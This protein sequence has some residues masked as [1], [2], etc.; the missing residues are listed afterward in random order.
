VKS[1]VTRTQRFSAD[2]AIFSGLA[3]QLGG[4]FAANHG[5]QA[6]VGTLSCC[7]VS[8]TSVFWPPLGWWAR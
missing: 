1:G 6:A 8:I 5:A 4:Q 3:G 2:D 7:P